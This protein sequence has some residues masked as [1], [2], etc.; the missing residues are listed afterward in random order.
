MRS[1]STRE[2]VRCRGVTKSFGS[3]EATVSALRGVDLD[4]YDGELLLLAGPSGCGKTTL[5]SIIGAMLER[6]A[7][8]CEVM[9]LDPGKLGR[10]EQ[11]Q[12]RGES[13]GF[14]FQEFNLLPA[15]TAR[16]NVAVPLLIA[17]MP[18]RSALDR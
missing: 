11:A 18:H 17:G 9:G 4:V 2:I 14:V 1:T 7:G 3:G 15:L 6:D 5:L 10:R 13:V 12:F 16:E 8:E